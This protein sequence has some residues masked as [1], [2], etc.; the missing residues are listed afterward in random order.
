[1]AV[2]REERQFKIGPIGVA[3]ASQGGQIVGEAI[4]NS[5][6]QM[7]DL[8]YREAVAKAEKTGLEAGA[9]VERE[10]VI[11]INPKTGEPEAYAAPATFGTI[12]TE[13]YQR[14]V[15]G[16]FQQSIEEEI[17]NK[18]KELAVKYEDS[19][20]AAALYESAM[21]DY[22]ASMSNAAEGQFKTYIKDVGTTYLNATRTSM[23]ITQ[24][25]RERAAAKEAHARTIEAGLQG[26]EG[27]VAQYGPSALNGPTQVQAVIS[28]VSNTIKD[29]SQAGLF[30]TKVADGM[31]GK[32]RLAV[33]RGLI[34][35]ASTQTKDPQTLELLQ[36]AI[37]T[38]NPNAVPAEFKYV[39]D[40]M[41]GLG[42][43]FGALADLEKFSDGLL[44]DSIQYNKVLEAQDIAAQKAASAARVF[45]M[46]N[47]LPAVISTETSLTRNADF[48]TGAIVTRAVTG[49][50]QLTNEARAALTGGDEDLS[51]ATIAR[52]N[53]IL[54]AQAE[55]LYLRA[56]AGLSRNE[57]NQLEQAVF[58]RNPMVA[59]ASARSAVA[60]ILRLDSETGQP[61]VDNFLPFIGSYR[62]GAGK[63][64]DAQRAADAAD[65]AAN[66]D[67]IGI[68]STTTAA[69]A[70]AKINAIAD[71][72]PTLRDTLVKTA[73]FNGSKASVNQFFGGLPSEQQID[74]AKS[75]LEGGAFREGV[76]T[77]NQIDLLAAARD[78]ATVAGKTS[79]LRT[80]FNNQQDVARRRRDAAEKETKRAA[81]LEQINMGMGNGRDR[82]TRMLFEEDLQQRY[83]SVL[84]DRTLASIW[85]DPVAI[86]DKNVRPIFDELKGK[87]I[88]PESLHNALTQFARGAWVGGDPNALL[89]HY[90]NFRGYYFEGVYMD[91]PMM[92]A[93][94]TTELVMLDYLNDTIPV[95]G[96]ESPARI[97]QMFKVGQ[98][99]QEDAMFQAKIKS[100]LGDQTVEE[101]VLGLKN[102]E[103]VPFSGMNAMI[104]ATLN[105]YAIS[106]SEG[107]SADQIK[108]R[109]EDQ[110]ERTYPS[111]GGY[112]FGIG[113]SQRTRFPIS[114]AAA[115]NEDAFRE[116]VIN[117]I[118]EVTNGT[119]VYFGKGLE[120][121]SWRDWGAAVSGALSFHKA[122]DYFY[123]QPVVG[124]DPKGEVSYIV[125]QRQPLEANGDRI[126]MDGALP[127]VV[128]NRDTAFVIK[129]AA[130][131]IAESESEVQRGY[132]IMQDE[133]MLMQKSFGEIEGLQ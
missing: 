131:A 132:D 73:Q 59:P 133:D 100:F 12:A 4:A 64:V 76:L 41:R 28:S 96:N 125:K 53:S 66:I 39:A 14:V 62:D 24:L 19:P 69:E 94:T 114:K 98:Q 130:R 115:G 77:Q 47:E 71:L 84:G 54:E 102:I 113:D 32:T 26:V 58:E 68:D 80:V 104:A 42:T 37:G 78:N 111:G 85:S 29:G 93:L 50:S 79:E 126:V 43:D 122:P 83:K 48:S 101:F 109:M 2:I 97:A 95:L 107:L 89:S 117:R 52:R 87:N 106:R 36:H 23:A 119:K 33:A 15:M 75:L 110:I 129:V 91:N 13:A 70:V 44:S 57:T 30:N 17:Q 118:T 22:I 105:L 116:H 99:Y 25:R 5:A 1:M 8:F 90:S 27:L 65:E 121:G 108:S 55:G 35:H 49:F 92:D 7:A 46:E 51:K 6:N 3:R 128:S 34:R 82:E 124:S 56:T 10:K 88:M 67:I 60:A 103:D 63:A 127:L 21:S 31:N 18:G 20:N 16:R 9:A 112:V 72:D 86:K 40:A 11:G 74:E 123:L 61:I 120:S 81:A 38:Q 45:A